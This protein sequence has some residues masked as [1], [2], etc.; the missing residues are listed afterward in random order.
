[1]KKN[2]LELI[3]IILM[4]IFNYGIGT[5][6]F[7]KK[8]NKRYLVGIVNKT[9]YH[10]FNQGEI[11]FIKNSLI[12][13][14]F[15]FY[16]IEGLNFMNKNI[17]EIELNSIFINNFYNLK[18][19][20]IE[21]NNIS[22]IGIRFL[23]K[24]S[25]EFLEFLNLSNNNIDDK[26]LQYL[27]NLSNL[28]ELI[29]LKMKLSDECFVVLG[30]FRFYSKINIIEC[31]KK[32][33][34]IEVIYENFKNFKLQNL[35]SIKFIVK[36]ANIEF[37]IYI[38]Y[39]LKFLFSL[40]NICLSLKTLDLSDI[41][42]DDNG[43]SILKLNIYKLKNIETINLSKNKLTNKSKK[44][45]KYLNDLNIT[46]LRDQSILLSKPFYK[47]LLAG[48]CGIGKTSYLNCLIGE[49]ISD[50]STTL[51]ISSIMIRPDFNKNIGVQL[52]DMPSWGGKF[53]SINKIIFPETDGIL[54][55]FDITV[56]ENFKGLT[57]CLSLINNYFE[58]DDFPVLLIAN[59]I[60][61]LDKRVIFEEEIRQF[62]KDNKL[63][64]FFE[65]SCKDNF[66]V[67]ESFN[68]L[69]NYINKKEEKGIN[70]SNK[71]YIILEKNNF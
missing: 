3:F 5:P 12:K 24:N 71:I 56:R 15:E 68:F 8:N 61:L 31:D 54:L 36:G 33:L 70:L 44:N 53:D 43:L 52:W 48:N 60:D 38:N 34:I 1:M 9:N 66:N 63:I 58:L 23:D 59:K 4:L 42:L 35:T 41:F 29:I 27:K 62:Q 40:N 25:F 2:Q 14:E 47:V 10:I 65:V 50:F 6:I 45:L 64:G 22:N 13:N 7:I 16:E 26:G 19:L 39:Y 57:A 49:K 67:K 37:N 46:I 20:N 17:K 32:K 30:K 55:L 18:Y 69:I 28:K 51:S 21:N 11:T